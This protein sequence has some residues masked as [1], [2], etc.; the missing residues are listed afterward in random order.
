MLLQ[1]DRMAVPCC[2]TATTVADPVKKQP[3]VAVVSL[4]NSSSK[5]RS[6]KKAEN[7]RPNQLLRQAPSL[8]LP[9][10]LDPCRQIPDVIE[11]A[12]ETR[13]VDVADEV[14]SLLAQNPVLR[15]D[16][17]T[18]ILQRAGAMLGRLLL[19]GFADEP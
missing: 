8:L 15:Q 11:I 2:L 16:I 9:I 1:P 19:R 13:C 4:S 10:A 12:N 18:V 14:I 17:T 5:N 6:H 3:S 7:S